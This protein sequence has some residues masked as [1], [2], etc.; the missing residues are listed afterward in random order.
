MSKWILIGFIATLIIAAALPVYAFNEANRMNQAQADLRAESVAVGQV[1]F[2][3]NCVVCHG[4]DG[5]GIGTYPGLDNE[6]VR[7]MDYDTLF[8]T[9][10]RGRY[11][12]AMAAWGVQ[13][14]GVLND[15]DINQLIAMLQQ[16]DWAA[17][18][19]TV[20]DL[21]LNPPTVISVEVSDEIL[22]QVA[23]LPHG[24]T[25]ARALPLFAANCAGCHG[26]DGAGTAIAPALNSP[27]LR[28]KTDD[29]VRRTITSG[30]AG[31]LMAGWGQALTS[32]QIEDM[33]GL[34]RYWAE[35]PLELIPAAELPPIASTD[36]EIIAA[37]GKLYNIACSQCHGSQGQGTRM[38]PALNVKSFLSATNDQALKAIIAQ[39]VPNTRMPAW[40]G[41]LSEAELTSLV[42]FIRA[43]EPNAPAVAQ[44]AAG[45]PGSQGPGGGQGQGRGWRR[46]LQSWFQ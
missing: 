11:N 30:V 8:K 39:G 2:A 19:Q 3:E 36:A 18:S 27:T 6:G 13:E 1:T 23:A 20:A 14:G 5:Q 16:G 7:A 43:W 44:P 25:L 28:Q 41:R 34:I 21:G 35:L 10:E 38:A 45:G 17:T 26:S 4:A 22:A 42:S 40:G 46:W 32:P 33:V 31:T 37:G 15:M 12:T 9:I 29:E 24:D